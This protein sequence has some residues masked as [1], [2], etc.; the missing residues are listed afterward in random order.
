MLFEPPP[1]APVLTNP[2]NVPPI[3]GEG[4]P[5]L[6]AP[7]PPPAYGPPDPPPTPKFVVDSPPEPPPPP[8]TQ[9]SVDPGPGVPNTELGFLNI[10]GN[11]TPIPQSP[12][13]DG[14][15]ALPPAPP[16]PPPPP[17]L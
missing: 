6:V 12:E 15:L 7:F 16:A 4:D 17:A 10:D 14:L 11:L 9:K 8:A 1:P 2:G 13:L 3:L 5:V